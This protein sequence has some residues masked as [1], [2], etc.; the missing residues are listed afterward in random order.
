MN[1]GAT[2]PEI[3]VTIPILNRVYSCRSQEPGVRRFVARCWCSFVLLE[4]HLRTQL[5]I[6]RNDC[7]ELSLW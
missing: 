5:Y 3:N 2:I 7:G 4:I 6:E 1:K